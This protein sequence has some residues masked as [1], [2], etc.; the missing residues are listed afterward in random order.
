[1]KRSEGRLVLMPP[2]EL[3]TNAAIKIVPFVGFDYDEDEFKPKPGLSSA[4]ANNV[5]DTR[6]IESRLFDP[7][8]LQTK[9]TTNPFDT[10]DDEAVVIT[11]S[12]PVVA[13]NDSKESVVQ[14]QPY[15]PMGPISVLFSTSIFL[16]LFLPLFSLPST[17]LHFSLFS[18]HQ[19]IPALHNSVGGSPTILRHRAREF[20]S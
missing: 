4:K 12:G 20:G 11:N 3:E 10:D 6:E 16:L 13:R 5:V 7:P 18:S 2:N 19:Q 8:S 9:K 15:V 17:P 14:C 1:M